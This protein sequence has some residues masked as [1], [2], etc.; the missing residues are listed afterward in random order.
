MD[1]NRSARFVRDEDGSATIEA[2][3]WLP[4]MFALLCLAVDASLIFFGQNQ[5]HRVVQEAN[6]T[7]SV[8]RLSGSDDVETYVTNAISAMSPNAQ[9]D[10]SI[11][12]GVVSTVVRIPSSDLAITG[13]LDM[14]MN[15]TV[16]V[17]GRHFVEY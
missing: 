11:S 1:Q 10:S 5:T 16:T 13:M 14:L 3:L 12:Q 8:G 4:V 7:L 17:G 9:V 15:I 2:V 6:R